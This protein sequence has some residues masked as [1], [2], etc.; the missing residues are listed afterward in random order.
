MF[1]EVPQEAINTQK[2]KIKGKSIEE[3]QK[4]WSEIEYIMGA[5]QNLKMAMGGAIMG[6]KAVED[7]VTQ[8]MLLRIQGLYQVCNDP[9]VL[10]NLKF[11]CIKSTCA[12][13]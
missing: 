10:D 8:F 9:D 5:K 3:L 4:I 6:I 11:I 13:Y 2:Y 1:R 7:L 12:K